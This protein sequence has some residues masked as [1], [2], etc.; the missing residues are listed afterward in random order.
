MFSFSQ[1]V[2]S[3]LNEANEHNKAYGEA[4]E[5]G[6][7]LHVHDNTAAK[8]NKDASYQKKIKVM[9][10][11]HRE[12]MSSLPADKAAK[13]HKAAQDSGHAYIES[14]AN[15]HGMDASKIHEVHHTHSGIDEHIGHEVSRSDNPHDLVVKGKKGKSNFLHGASLK[16]RSGTASNNGAGTID[17]HLGTNLMGKWKAHKDR[18]GLGNMS[19]KE[20]K[21]V[22]DKPEIVKKNQAAQNDA[23]N[24][25]SSA[26]QSA[27]LKTQ[28]EHLHRLLKGKPDMAYDYV[29][30]S[31]KGAKAIPH[32]KIEHLHAVKNAKSF[33]TKVKNN[34]M[35]VYDHE[36]KHVAAI[37][38]RPTHGS[39]SSLQVNAKYGSMKKGVEE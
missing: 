2:Q 34:V 3:I 39:F 15:N 31:N 16:A 1:F 33:S 21:A 9:R 14:L 20:I 8:S 4:Y 29:S 26:F 25:H 36:G 6:T 7:V 5:L 19:G 30:A 38:H 12:L 24:H 22:R 17:S 27:D 10:A 28:K 11:R 37:E 35:H 13:A 23:A 18:A 32:D